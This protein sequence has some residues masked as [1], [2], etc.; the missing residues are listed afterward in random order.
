MVGDVLV[1]RG[2]KAVRGYGKVHLDSRV[3]RLSLRRQVGSGP[4][5]VPVAPDV[6][7]VDGGRDNF[8]LFQGELAGSL[9][10]LAV[11]GDARAPVEVDPGAVATAQV[12]EQVAAA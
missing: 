5:A 1:S 7:E 3:G 6:F 10:D 11:Q 4:D 2:E 9:E 8:D 12:T